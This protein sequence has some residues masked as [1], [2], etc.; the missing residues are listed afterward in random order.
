M[1]ERRGMGG[2]RLGAE[3]VAALAFAVASA[4]AQVDAKDFSTKIMQPT[5]KHI[6]THAHADSHTHTPARIAYGPL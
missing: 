6:H 1:G 2:C 3:S 4:Y 5:H